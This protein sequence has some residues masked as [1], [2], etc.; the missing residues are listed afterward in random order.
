MKRKRMRVVIV[1]ALFA[2]SI[3]L[4]N[5][6]ATAKAEN[7]NNMQYY[8]KQLS[9][10]A[11]QIYDALYQMYAQGIFKTGTQEYDLVGNGHITKEQLAAYEGSY[12]SLLRAYGAAR[13]AFYA[14]YPDI[15]YVDF[16]NIAIS[17]E[18][19]SQD[20]YKAYLG[21]REDKPSYYVE[22]FTDQQQVESAISAH[23]AKVNEIVQGAKSSASSV[24]EQIIYAH[25][26]I[27]GN[28]VYRLENNCSAGN[29][30]HIRTSY[31]A[32]VK[33]ESL[34]E[35][36]ARAVKSVL[37]SMGITSVLVQGYYQETD[38]SKNL[39]M[40]NYVQIDGKWYAIDATADDGMS[41]GGSG[42]DAYLLVDSTVMNKNHI[43][44]GIMSEA[45]YRFTYPSLVSSQT[46]G[47]ASQGGATEG[48]GTG[49]DGSV[50]GGDA[51]VEGSTDSE[52]YKVL[53]S[54]NGLVVEYRD[55]T[56][57][58]QET[59]V[60]KVSYKGLGYQ[61]AV[62]QEGVYILTRFYR[63]VPATGEL[64]PDNW[65]YSDP[66][67][68]MLPELEDALVLPNS[69]SKIIEFA[70]T[71][72]KPQ[73][74]LYG[75]NLTAEEVE[76]N[77]KFHGT[78]SDFIAYSGQ[79][80][81]PKGNFVPSPFARYLTPSPTSNLTCGKKYTI[82][83]V[84]N[85]QLEEYDGQTAGYDLSV[86]NGW[87]A[88]KNSKIENFKWDGDRT[89][90]FDFTPSQMLA[91]NDAEY[92]FKITG[93]R[94]N[95]SL[96][97][98]DSFSY[99]AKK[100]ISTCAFRPQGYY[101]NLFGRPELLEPKD[102]SCNDWKLSTGEALGDVVND[103]LLVASKPELEVTIPSEEQTKEMEDKIEE[104]G[105]T[106]VA[107]STYHI[108]LRMCR[109]DIIHT[110]D[111]VRVSVG[112]PEGYGLENV[113]VTYKAFHFVK[114]NGKIVGVE[115]IG[116]AVTEFGLV[117]TC[118]SFSPFAVVAV[119][120]EET[121]EAVK[122]VL[123]LNSAGGE[124]EGDKICVLE[125]AESQTVS[126]TAKDGYRLSSINL[127]GQELPITD[128]KSMNI[129]LA[130]DK[131][132]YDENILDVNFVSEKQDQT[133]ANQNGQSNTPQAANNAPGN[134]A[135]SQAPVNN[136]PDNQGDNQQSDQ[137]GN[138]ENSQQSSQQNNQA[139][140]QQNN[141]AN[142]QQ[143]NQTNSQPNNQAGSQQNNQTPQ[144]SHSKLG[145]GLTAAAGREKDPDADGTY[146]DGTTAAADEWA[147]ADNEGQETMEVSWPAEE[148]GGEAV[149][150]VSY[151]R[152]QIGGDTTF[153]IILASITG[154]GIIGVAIVVFMNI[155]R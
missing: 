87:S 12:E 151:E 8:S 7:K 58:E 53:F 52:G 118:K 97:E 84:F 25:D 57:F 49:G 20:G 104:L 95:G 81:N 24:K 85:E 146:G 125:T 56:E 28:T 133:A 77:W 67:P 131:L 154:V 90:T 74:P 23:D 92:T 42:S 141:Q 89:I 73:G 75:D 61:Q 43:P 142:G 109:K 78:E 50:G 27:I 105:N 139:G 135:V 34:C 86:R 39:H 94:G 140:A 51:P 147:Y 44:D 102:L 31:G 111:S 30:G 138:Q 101:W 96:K 3:C 137:S 65:G 17:V 69:N 150:E 153:L 120:T 148:V 143:S 128:S 145:S 70:V 113:G 126:V 114:Q 93:L 134:G 130:Y 33:G 107:S 18:E 22:G 149:T 112:F 83:A 99:Y 16:S 63:Y 82:T 32:L 9:A 4:A 38:G 48:D 123:L 68:F 36:Y 59:G 15:F 6:N 88:I 41:N 2:L 100:K 54:E 21:A 62:D 46:E 121:Q 66:K 13:D 19:S 76:N 5:R 136:Q 79:L 122:K 106:I 91:D 115:E 117:I 64:I 37:D 108:D 129:E 71:K 119:E 98:P 152:P 124:V 103:L 1:A 116:C 80:E 144:A 72:V 11:K 45:G 29:K 26:A 35:G 10:E 40:W 47:D 155:R 110:G 55:G 132:T 60:F 127:S 14:D